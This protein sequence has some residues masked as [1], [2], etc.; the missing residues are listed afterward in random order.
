[1]Q[2]KYNTTK[3][4]DTT[5]VPVTPVTVTPQCY[6]NP[7]YASGKPEIAFFVLILS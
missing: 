3:T 1:M 5:P 2:Q 4:R 6:Q 7:C